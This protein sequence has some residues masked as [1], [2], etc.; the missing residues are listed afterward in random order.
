M[1]SKRKLNVFFLIGFLTMMMGGFQ[2]CAEQPMQMEEGIP[3]VDGQMQIVDQIHSLKLKFVEREVVVE[4]DEDEI[5]LHGFCHRQ[6]ADGENFVWDLLD[7]SGEVIIE[8]GHSIC[9]GGGFQVELFN[10][11]ELSCDESY[12]IRV[13]SEDGQ[14]DVMFLQKNC[15]V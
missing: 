11:K 8:G 4:S 10:L 3:I 2:N 14:D 5:M 15:S 9:S 1:L 7:S 13:E 6:L 12:E